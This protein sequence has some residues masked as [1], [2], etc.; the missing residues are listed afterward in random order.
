MTQ[1]WIPIPGR[2]SKRFAP[3]ERWRHLCREDNRWYVMTRD[4]LGFGSDFRPGCFKCGKVPP[5]QD[6]LD[7]AKRILAAG[8]EMYDL[9]SQLR[10]SR[11]QKEEAR[12]GWEEAKRQS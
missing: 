8:E 9:L 3:P 1:R 5:L 7:R 4:Q 2:G 6:N 12:R 10:I 11:A